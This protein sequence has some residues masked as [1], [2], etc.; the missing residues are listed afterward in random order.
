LFINLKEKA[1]FNITRCSN[2]AFFS[3]HL[4]IFS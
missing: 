4:P 2:H 1:R 3:K